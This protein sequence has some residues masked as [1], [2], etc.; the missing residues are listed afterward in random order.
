MDKVMTLAGGIGCRLSTWTDPEVNELIPFYAEL[1]HLYAGARTLPRSRQF[2][3]LA[4]IIDAAVQAAI[5]HETPSGE[6]LRR[7]QA[8]AASLN[9]AD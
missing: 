4:H 6:I 5:Q 7:A 9:L 1:P 3:A 8:E 2:P